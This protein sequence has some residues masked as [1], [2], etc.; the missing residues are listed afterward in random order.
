[1][2]DPDAPSPILAGIGGIAVVVE[3]L[4]RVASVAG[5]DAEDIRIHVARRLS[6]SGVRVVSFESIEDDPARGILYVRI[7]TDRHPSGVVALAVDLQICEG[8]R[9]ARDED[10]AGG[11]ITWS[12]GEV[13]AVD[14]VALSHRALEDVDAALERLVL[15]I[16]QANREVH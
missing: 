8:A 15:A 3:D 6:D 1:M 10:V 2:E 7:S 4:D 5:L 14:S 9:L 12:T 11:V 16:R 13:R